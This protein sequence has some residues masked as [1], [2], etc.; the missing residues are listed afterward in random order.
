MTELFETL[1]EMILDDMP[2]E[3][4]LDVCMQVQELER[5]ECLCR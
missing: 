2:P 1:A 5:Q 4:L 3:D